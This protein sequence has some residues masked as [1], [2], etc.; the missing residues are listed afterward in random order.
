M[1]HLGGEN[2]WGTFSQE[3]CAIKRKHFK[4]GEKASVEICMPLNPRISNGM[5]SLRQLCQ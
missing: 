1:S 5:D 4:R 2:I 3:F